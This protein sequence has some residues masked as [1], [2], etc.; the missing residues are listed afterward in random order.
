LIRPIH[1]AALAIVSAC[2]APA[3]S[4]EKTARSPS[5]A[6]ADTLIRPSSSPADSVVRP[7]TAIRVEHYLLFDSAAVDVDGD[8]ADER[9][10]LAAIMSRDEDGKLVGDDGAQWLVAVRDGADTYPLL[11]EFLPGGAAFWIIAGDSL[12]PAAILVQTSSLTTSGG[13]TRLEKFVF[14]RARGGYARTG[15]V[16]AFG[17]A[18][19]YRGPDEMEHI[20]PPTLFRWRIP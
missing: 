12:R 7:D 3:E 18:V 11:D 10:D 19:Q 16:E 6:S 13:G 20:L 17:P 2:G 4:A 14:D 5:S 1:L 9:I 8:G 15:V